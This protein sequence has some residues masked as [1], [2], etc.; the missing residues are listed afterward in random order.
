MHYRILPESIRWLQSQGRT[1]EVKT[2]LVRAAKINGKALSD[3]EFTNF[4]LSPNHEKTEEV[5]S[6][7]LRHVY[8]VSKFDVLTVNL[9]LPQLWWWWWW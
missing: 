9:H 2:I 6:S 3:Q 4:E 8:F 7:L 5:S 1:S